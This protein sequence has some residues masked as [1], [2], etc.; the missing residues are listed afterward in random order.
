V[1]ASNRSTTYRRCWPAGFGAIGFGA[2]PTYLVVIRGKA[3]LTQNRVR[4]IL[5]QSL[6]S[7]TKFA[8]THVIPYSARRSWDI[9]I[10]LS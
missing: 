10:G 1:L 5:T 2:S 8:W 4:Q 3:D 7:A 6:L 9:F